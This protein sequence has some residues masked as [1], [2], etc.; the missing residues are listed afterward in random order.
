[1]TLM[2]IARQ[3]RVADCVQVE[4]EC[5][6]ST[7]RLLSRLTCSDHHAIAAGKFGFV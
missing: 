3:V 2:R 5:G 4:R 1:M 7:T 6:R